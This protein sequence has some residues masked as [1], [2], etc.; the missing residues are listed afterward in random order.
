MRAA[1]NEWTQ[2]GAKLVPAA[3]QEGGSAEFGRNVALSGDGATALIGAPL[4]ERRVGAAWAFT[5]SG[6]AWSQQ[7]GKLTGDGEVSKGQFGSAV[8]LSSDGSTAL[9]GAS[10]EGFRAGAAYVL[11]RSG[12]TWAQRARLAGSGKLA[13]SA[14]GASVALSSDGAVALVGGL[15]D[16]GNMGAAWVFAD[17]ATGW[18]Q[19]GQKLTAEEE[20]GEGQFGWSVA[21]SGDATTALVGGLADDGDAGAAWVFTGEPFGPEE[22]EGGGGGGSSTPENTGASQS[23]PTNAGNGVVLGSG[24]VAGFQGSQLPAPVLGQS[25]NLSL[26][27]GTVMIELPG[28]NHFVAL[29]GSL[30]IPFG[31][32]I[33]ATHGSVTVTVMGPHGQ[34][35]TAHYFGGR[36]LLT[37]Q[38]NGVVVATLE[39]GN[40]A[41]CKRPAKHAGVTASAARSK[42]PVRKLWTNAH[43]SFT[44]KGTYAAG[45]VQGT[46]WLTEDFCAST[47]VIVTR[48]KVKVTDLVRHR[49]VIV[50]AGHRYRAKAK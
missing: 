43:G 20:E 42:K 34:L 17:N 13:P 36:F 35:E 37:Q 45:A 24:G 46:E 44:T 12:S 22:P 11:S 41:S 32:I 33:D 49:S 28:T 21:L 4:D 47:L 7:G 16:D 30:H 2:Q 18:H 1:R 48:D 14:F 50:R 29:K 3:G 23:G 31:T 19:Q 15:A 6:G 40:F 38:P 27:S 8:A 5:W 10:Q 39:G 26:V 9:V 25:G